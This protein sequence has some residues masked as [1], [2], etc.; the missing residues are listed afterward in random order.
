MEALV[1]LWRLGEA[2]EAECHEQRTSYSHFRGLLEGDIPI[3]TP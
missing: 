3:N 1:Q 2:W